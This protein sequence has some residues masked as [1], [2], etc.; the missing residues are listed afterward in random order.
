MINNLAVIKN[1]DINFSSKYT[2]L[3]GETGAGKS[4]VVD[5]LSL[6]R[7][8]KFDASLIRDKEKKTIISALFSIDEDFLKKHQELSDMVDENSILLVKRVITKDHISKFYINDELFTL[9]EYKRI[10]EHLIDIHSQGSNSDILNES[11]QLFYLDTFGG[12]SISALKIA[13]ETCYKQ[14]LNKQHELNQLLDDAKGY[15]RDYL[16]YQIKEITKYNLKPNEIEDLND[17]FTSLRQYDEIKRKHD[18][19]LQ[20]CQQSDFE[21]KD[22]LYRLKNQLSHF[23]NT[24]LSESASELLKS[25]SSCIDS[26]NNF[27]EDFENLKFDPNRIDE[28]NQRLFDLKGL[29]RKYGK[30]TQAILDNLNDYQQKLNN[31]EQFEVKKYN[32]EKEIDSCELKAKDAALALSCKRKEV[33]NDLINKINSELQS[34]GLT[35]GG[36]NITFSKQPLSS[37]GIDKISF[38]IQ[39]NKGLDETSLAK[40]ASGGES[41]RLMLALKSVLNNLD[42]YNVLVFDEVDTGVS[43]RIASLVAKKIRSISSYSQVIVISHLPQVVAS[44]FSAFRVS[45]MTTDGE[46]ETQLEEVEEDELTKEIAKLISGQK[47][48]ESALAQAVELRKEYSHE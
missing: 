25:L 32:L 43:G 39:M 1:G 20:I 23:E 22:I 2:A 3:I 33:A 17:E 19:F 41:S 28:I 24:E 35:N 12:K 7:G 47:I 6:L 36:F 27:E 42:P 40:A 5:A 38:V 21:F 9:N 18:E 10:V 16:E 4:L 45:K 8:G 48:T 15:D 34:L 37:N 30:T 13:F 31:I 26:F 44:T 14:Y 46:T 29:Q 11:K